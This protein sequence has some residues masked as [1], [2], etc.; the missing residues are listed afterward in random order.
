MSDLEITSLQGCP[1]AHR[2]AEVSPGV[3]LH[4]VEAGEGPLVV[5]LHGFP[6]FWYGFR[7]QIPA[8]A[9]A[10]FRVVAPDM[11]GYN[12][13]SRPADVGAY[14]SKLLAADIAGLIRAC[15]EERADVVGHDWGAGVAWSFAMAYPERLRRL[16]ILNGPHPLGLM[17]AFVTS[18]RQLARSWYMAFFQL[19]VVPERV[20]ARD[21]HAIL[22]AAFRKEARP[23]AFTTTDLALYREAFAQPGAL[24]A[25]VNYYRAMRHPSGM[26]RPAKVEAP[27]LVLWGDRDQHLGRELAHPP[28]RYVPRAT[29]VHLPAASHWVQHDAADEVNERLT[30]FLR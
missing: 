1:I 15:G 16:A 6:E 4:Y 13:S 9:A 24:T 25:M 2:Y 3:R 30:S 7:N 8:L 12:H 26:V 5:L 11:R 29:V 10:G 27:V 22:L 17:R 19:P 21:D 23:G 18:P 20:M 28:E 14:T